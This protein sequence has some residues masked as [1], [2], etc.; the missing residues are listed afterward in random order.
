MTERAFWEIVYRSL[1]AVATA[2]KKRHLTPQG[3]GA[4]A[5]S[6]DAGVVTQTPPFEHS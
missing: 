4:Q 3:S 6:G 1:L 5:G 2:I